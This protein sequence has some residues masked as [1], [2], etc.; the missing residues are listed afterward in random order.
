MSGGIVRLFALITTFRNHHSVP[1]HNCTNWNLSNVECFACKSQGEIHRL[2]FDR[3]DHG[4]G[5][6]IRTHGG[7]HL[8]RFPSVPIRPLSHPSKDDAVAHQFRVE[9][10]GERRPTSWR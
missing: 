5:G 9:A 10:I 8:T 1:Q 6:G 3:R 4:G 7:L 2:E